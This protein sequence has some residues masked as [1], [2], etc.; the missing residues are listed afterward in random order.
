MLSLVLRSQDEHTPT[1]AVLQSCTQ[2]LLPAAAKGSHQRIL[3]SESLFSW[4]ALQLF[5]A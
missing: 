1:T 2:N 3:I 4:F 5:S